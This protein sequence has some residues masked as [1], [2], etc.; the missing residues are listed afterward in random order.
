MKL[1]DA[2]KAPNPRRVRIFMAEK[3][4][5]IPESVQIDMMKSENKSPA[6]TAVNP[7]QRMPALELDDGTVIAESIA[8]C[9]Y[10]DELHPEPPLFGTGAL[11][12]ALVEMWN[13]RMELGL[14]AAVAAVFR[15]LHPA[16][17]VLE[18]P[19]IATW[20]EANKARAAEELARLD[21]ALAGKAFI[22]GDHFSVADITAGVAVDFS[23]PA[24]VEVPASL[25][26]VR[27]W[28]DSLKARPSWN[29]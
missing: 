6:Y 8:I 29:A 9:R 14:L 19:Q 23:K 12:K 3:G 7:W 16:A 15:H 20:G 4:L 28:H 5:S 25:A 13:R 24:K 21:A 18:V 2:G 26:N 1:Y 11:G 27:R 22:C 10:F 17:A